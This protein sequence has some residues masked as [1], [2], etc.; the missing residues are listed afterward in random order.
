[1]EWIVN[2]T[3][4]INVTELYTLSISSEVRIWTL[5]RYYKNYLPNIIVV[6]IG[7]K[8]SACR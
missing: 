8:D 6:Q 3:L 7:Q 5:Y 2:R 1:M 4:N